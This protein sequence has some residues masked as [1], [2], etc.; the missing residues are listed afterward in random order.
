MLVAILGQLVPPK[1]KFEPKYVQNA[2]LS[3]RENSSVLLILKG[4]W[5]D[6][7]RNYKHSQDFVEEETKKNAEKTSPDRLIE[8]LE[9]GKRYTDALAE[10]GITNVGHILDKLK[11]GEAALLDIAGVGRKTLIDIKKKLRQLGYK[12]PAAAEEIS[13]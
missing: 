5:I 9:L 4:R 1:K 13:V 3:S 2:I 10:A 7:T 11:G 12:L 6:S 8:E